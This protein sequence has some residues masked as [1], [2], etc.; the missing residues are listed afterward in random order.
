MA[1][2][3]SKYTE[4]SREPDAVRDIGTITTEILRL[5]QDAG[6]AIL[7]I[8]QRLIEAQAMLPHGEWLP[9]LTEQVEVSAVGAGMDKSASACRFGSRKSI[10]AAGFAAGG[11]GTLYGGKPCRGW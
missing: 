7:S 3:I 8:G 11:A 4:A 5:K 6:N 2:D 10:D 1:F 9:W